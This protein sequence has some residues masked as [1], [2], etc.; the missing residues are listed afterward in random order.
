MRF[1]RP[2]TADD[3][4]LRSFS[5]EADR[6]DE[7]TAVA[8]PVGQA[9]PV[10]PPYQWHEVPG[11]QGFVLSLDGTWLPCSVHNGGRFLTLDGV[12]LLELMLAVKKKPD[13][14]EKLI[15]RG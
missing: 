15:T 5:E 14:V 11:S 7:F 6:Y 2:G 12:V 1:I 3:K 8:M 4:T 13:A 9:L 10:V